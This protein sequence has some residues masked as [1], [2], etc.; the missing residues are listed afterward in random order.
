MA[1]ADMTELLQRFSRG[2][3]EAEAELFRHVFRELHKIARACLRGERPEHTLQAT[4]LVNEVYMKLMA[5]P[6]I[7][8]QNRAHFFS[9][10]ARGMRRILVDYA[11]Q[12]AAA[13]RAG[14]RIELD[15]ALIV[16]P[17]R[18]TEIDALHE[19]LERLAEFAPRA[20]KVVEMRYFGGLT[21]EEIAGVLGVSSKTVKRDW[22]M[23]VGWLRGELCQ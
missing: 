16:S 9:L 23:A 6:Q 13:K 4:A 18:C 1:A 7:D 8:W 21:E 5:G 20:A 12:R 19:A 10:A 11:R 14:V 15:E 2:D 22:Q 17:E 3:K